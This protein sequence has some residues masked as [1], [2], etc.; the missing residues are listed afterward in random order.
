MLW[1]GGA[2]GSNP[3]HQALATASKRGKLLLSR[4]CL[5]VC[6]DPQMALEISPGFSVALGHEVN[7]GT[8]TPLGVGQAQVRTEAF[9][10]ERSASGRGGLSLPDGSVRAY[11]KSGVP[12]RWLESKGT[13]AKMQQRATTAELI[14]QLRRA[15]LWSEALTQNNFSDFTTQ[16]DLDRSQK[17]E[18]PLAPAAFLSST[19]MKGP[20]QQPT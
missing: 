5:L 9:H 8:K 17:C 1:T 13:G 2:A 10:P 3:R 11:G 16:G 14:N 20:T 7:A 4:P 6:T 15:E 18:V 12:D 19:K